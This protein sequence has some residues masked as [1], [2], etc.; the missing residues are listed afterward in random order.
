MLDADG[1][2]FGGTN[3]IVAE[4]DGTLNSSNTDTNFNMTM[5]SASNYP[6]FGFSPT[7]HHMRVF[8]PGN[9]SFDSTCSVSQ[10]ESGI[11]NCGGVTEDLLDLNIGS[12]QVGVHML[13]DWT[14]IG[15]NSDHV[16]IDIAVLWNLNGIFDSGADLYQGPAGPTPESDTL[17]QLVSV[18]GD[19][20]GA[21]GMKMIDGPFLEFSAN[22][23]LKQVPIPPALYLFCVGFAGLIGISRSK[24]AA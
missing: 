1:V 19:G 6:F 5:R 12:E 2:T 16:N 21:P 17:Y 9:Y 18:D 8:G 14:N 3:D 10:L 15:D 23:N 7:Y 20:N 22:Y 11:A 24:K 13:M 4:W